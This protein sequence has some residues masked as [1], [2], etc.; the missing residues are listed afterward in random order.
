[1]SFSTP[2]A[3]VLLVCI[4]F[5]LYLG[6]P[7]QRFRRSRD[8]V[9]LVLRTLIMLLLV[10]A[11]A[12]VQL[13]RSA[14]RLAVVFLVDVSDSMG[15]AAQE[16]ALD[17]V[18]ESLTSLAPDDEAGLILF[19]T[20][21]L[22]ERPLSNLRELGTILSTPPTGNTDMEEA[23][24]LAMGILPTDAARR[25]MILSDGRATIGDAES[26]AELAAA[27]GI[28]ISYVIFT[29]EATPEVQVTG[30]EA[31]STVNA[32]QDFD[33][34][35][36]IESEAATSATITVLASG[37]VIKRQAVELRAGTTNLT[38]P[39]T[40]GGAGFK[41]FQVQVEPAGS[42]GF[43]Q[44]NQLS[45][46][47]RV[48][49]PP[50]AL[51]L[52]NSEE[53]IRY[54][55]PA[56][57]QAGLTVDAMQPNELPIGL[58]GLAQY[59]SIVMA[60]IAATPL[61]QERMEAIQSFV[62][63]LGGGLVVIGGPNAYAP[64][65]YF[66][67]PLEEVLPLNMQVKDQQRLP[68][69]T[70]AYVIDRSGSM[71]AVGTS[72][73]ENIELA[74]EAIIRSI[75]F[76][77]ATD[78]AGV[79]SFDSQG[80]WIANI[81]DV[82]DRLALQRLVA[83]LRT[84]GGTDILAGMN[85]VA[86]DIINDP[87]DRK[88][89]IL[90]TDGG[91]NPTGLVELSQRLNTDYGITT[92]VIAIGAGSA[93]FLADMAEAGDGNYHAVDIV[94]QIPLIFA[95]E[96]V[97]AT[98]SYILENSFVPSLSATSPIMNGITS[99]PPLL[100]YVATSAKQTAEVILRGPEP[101]QDPILAS[102]QYGLGRSVAF[103]SDA[104]ARWGANW[105]SW[106]EYVRF[107]DQAVR[108]TITQGTTGNVET[109]VVMEGEQARLVVDARDDNGAFLN[110]L[111]LQ[112]SVVD[113]LSQAALSP[114]RQVAPGR[115][116]ATFKPENEGA[117]ILHVSG[118]SEGDDSTTID[119]TTG[120]VMSYSSEYDMGGAGDG[121]AVLSSLAGLTG[122]RSLQDEPSQVFAHNL[123]AQAAATPIWHWFMLFALLL[124]PFDIAVRRLIVTRSDWQRLRRYIFGRGTVEA[125][126][127]RISS[128]LG[129][130]ERG[131]QRAEDSG[132]SVA[133]LRSRRDQA[134]SEQPSTTSTGESQPTDKPRFTPSVNPPIAP[135]GENNVAGQ[136]LKKRKT[137][138]GEKP[139]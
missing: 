66:Q 109:R 10:F 77:Q 96:T 128:L 86:Q 111:N 15:Q 99:A 25:I 4:P 125:T 100:G 1:M 75:D 16:S 97:L 59:D 29:R 138:E 121:E 119:Q 124:L 79:V 104:T 41:D 53:E 62:R 54:L 76:L 8:T 20:N 31:P 102:W 28:E 2:L 51:L 123:A 132:S 92:S 33:L 64:G 70:I 44:N 5:V 19:G 23:I 107:W 7:R 61:P 46:F 65:G 87:A 58:V 81:Q 67:T 13:V 98:R 116:E 24:R 133:A 135:T 88:H 129:A 131:R 120:W 35:I 83:S 11:L 14:D 71:G 91:A 94:E 112:L 30:F 110:G 95:Q 32:G 122:G 69:L 115:Y 3:L 78:R 139:K 130:K 106:G 80:Y 105:V 22:V 52:Y 114:L 113:P 72:G 27:T 84:G 26:A 137:R 17:Y 43:Y 89:I 6:W 56:L 118:V 73:I 82:Q 57:E 34:T 55:Q 63:D 45:T 42:D 49:G 108:W 47:S 136:L 117:Y 74:K 93:S 127:E 21:A 90:L 101:F 50:R 9:S 39:L 40:G 103:T 126:S 38:L 134:R 68:R 12:G 37:E 48:I 60:N 18:R 85:L 36:N